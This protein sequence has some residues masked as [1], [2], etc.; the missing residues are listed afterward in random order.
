MC[1]GTPQIVLLQVAEDE[2]EEEAHDGDEADE[3]A[4]FVLGLWHHG[5][6]EHRQDGPGGEGLDKGDQVFRSA[7][8]KVVAEQR[9]QRRDQR[10]PDPETEDVGCGAP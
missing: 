5:A 9:R 8:E 7:V 10:H 4:A 6:R 1:N 2:R 3:L